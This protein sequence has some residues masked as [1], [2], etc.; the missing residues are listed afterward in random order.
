MTKPSI[1]PKTALVLFI[2]LA[3]AGLAQAIWW[4]V[5]MA[6]LVNEKVQIATNLGADEDAISALQ[7]QE[8]ARQVMV[9]L[10]G[11]FFLVVIIAGAWLIYRALVK[12][13]EL[14]YHQQNF[15]MAVTHELK[16]PLASIMIYIDSLASPKISEERKLGILP[17]IKSDAQRLESLVEKILE[18]G[19]F[20]RSG[21]NLHK[22]R[23]DFS[24]L[25]QLSIERLKENPSDRSIIVE[26]DIA[27]NVVIIG[28]N[29]A[30][31]RT[32]E[33]LLDNA[34][35]YNDKKTVKIN[36]SLQYNNDTMQLRITDNGIGLSKK[37]QK[38]IFDRFYRVGS[39]LRRERSG[40]GLGLFLCRE[41][42]RAHDGTIKV[43]S[44][45]V[46]NG[47]TFSITLKIGN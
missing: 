38:R 28:D 36:I 1:T 43:K 32:V 22:E 44:E 6:G 12:T 20:D 42:I 47:S 16:T 25:V 10:E 18:A 45:G 46:G 23:I 4:T 11:I 13:N 39:E 2:A 29:S 15:L 40:S 14:N 21:A 35:R 19:K 9:G 24:K 31:T 33:S 8:I 26:S 7:K 37:D 3:T 41:I 30:L 5:F 27:S 17:R 34:V